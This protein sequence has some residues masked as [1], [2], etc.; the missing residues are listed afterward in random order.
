[1]RVVKK[2]TLKLIGSWV[3][4]SN[5]PNIVLENFIPP[6]LDA[7]LADYHRCTVPEAREPEVSNFF[8]MTFFRG[9]ATF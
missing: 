4:R 7:V 9:E 6:M 1:M 5:D 8:K 2:E 3:D